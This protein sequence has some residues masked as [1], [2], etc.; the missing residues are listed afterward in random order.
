MIYVS[1]G[2]VEQKSKVNNCH[3]TSFSFLAR[4]NLKVPKH[5][6]LASY[7]FL[8]RSNLNL[9]RAQ[10]SLGCVCGCWIFTFLHLWENWASRWSW[11]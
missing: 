4:A 9:P 7:R 2:L 5:P 10:V 6:C 8:P 3:G 11:A 1:A